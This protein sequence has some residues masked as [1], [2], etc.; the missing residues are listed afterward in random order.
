MA[1]LSLTRFLFK[2]IC[3]TLISG[4]SAAVVQS[5]DGPVS[6]NDQSQW[7]P[8]MDRRLVGGREVSGPDVA[9]FKFGIVR[10]AQRKIELW[11]RARSLVNDTF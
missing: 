7:A 4:T 3:V 8:S 11:V 2:V 9:L 10:I 1:K 5:A 6:D